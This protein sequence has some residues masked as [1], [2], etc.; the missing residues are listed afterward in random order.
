MRGCTGR[1][2]HDGRRDEQAGARAMGTPALLHYR[3]ALERAPRAGRARREHRRA[4]DA[5]VASP[6]H[7]RG[8]P[9]QRQ[10]HRALAVHRARV[11]RADRGARAQGAKPRR[12]APKRLDRHR[13]GAARAAPRAPAL[14]LP[15]GA[16]QPRRA[17]PRAARARPASRLRDGVS[18]H[19]ASRA[20]QA[21]QAQ[22]PRDRARLRAARA[23]ALRGRP[24]TRSVA[25]RLPRRQAQGAHGQRRAQGRDAVRHARRPL[26]PVLPRPVGTSATK[27][28][29]ASSTASARASRSAGC[30]A[31]CS[32]TTARP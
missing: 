7:R 28:P 16:R 12:H 20:R 3:A 31:P 5:L 21:S 15:A 23:P 22:T 18:L 13:R 14:E 26:A 2:G 1:R 4:R 17:R 29:R 32:A 6:D 27:T 10:E 8:D 9:V 24:R 11:R 19:E 30:R 25:L